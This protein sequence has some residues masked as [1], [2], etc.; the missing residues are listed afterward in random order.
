MSIIDRSDPYEVVSMHI[1]PIKFLSRVTLAALCAGLLVSATVVAAR[2]PRKDHKVYVAFGF[3]VNLYHSFRNDTNDEYGFG[4]DIRVI[5]HIISTLDRYN[6]QG[7]PVRGVWDFDNLFS[8]QERLPRYAP[9]IIEGIQRRVAGQGDEV[10]LMSYNNGLVS[11][12][13]HRELID[14]MQW[15]VSNPWGSGVKDLFARY[16]PI[17]RPQEMMTTPGNFSIYKDCAN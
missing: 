15:A 3:H 9:D 8:L 2:G 17:V 4:K 5:R 1:R 7:V 13:T 16:S 6:K 10:I 12:M 11:A 14:A